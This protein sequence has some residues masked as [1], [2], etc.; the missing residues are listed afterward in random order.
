VSLEVAVDGRILRKSDVLW[1]KI[2]DKVFDTAAT[3]H[4]QSYT[5]LKYPFVG[6]TCMLWC[7]LF[8]Q[9]LS[10]VRYC[11]SI[12][13]WFWLNVFIVHYVST[14]GTFLTEQK[15]NESRQF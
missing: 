12:R 5:V 3:L 13:F 8:L 7:S 14:G 4:K 9:C 11:K 15:K 2:K 10:S 6:D 1:S